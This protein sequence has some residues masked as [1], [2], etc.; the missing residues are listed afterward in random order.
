MTMDFLPMA[1]TCLQRNVCSIKED[2]HNRCQLSYARD[3]FASNLMYKV[4]EVSQDDQSLLRP[5][6]RINDAHRF[7]DNEPVGLLY[8]LWVPFIHLG[9][10]AGAVN[11]RVAGSGGREV[12]LTVTAACAWG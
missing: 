10:L 5:K 1:I 7:R 12:W 4:W 9:G 8:S 6:T 2:V 3:A 11:F